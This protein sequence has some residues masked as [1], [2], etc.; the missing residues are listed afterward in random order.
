MQ[1]L[2]CATVMKSTTEDL[3]RERDRVTGADLVELRLDGL[4][5]PD[6]AAALAG[7][8]LPVIVTCRPS[9]EG[10]GFTGTEDDR[11]RILER[12]LDLGADY[13]DLEAGAPFTQDLIRRRGGRR[14]VLSQHSFD[15][16]PADLP[17]RYAAMQASGAEVVKIA[18][19]ASRL[20]D[21]LPLFALADGR[22]PDF[23]DHVLIGMGAAG[24]PSR[25][26]GARLHNRW[27]YA[28]EGVA[29]G[30]FPVA[31]LLSTFRFRRI[32]ADAA[33]YGVV[34][35]PVMHSLSP[36]MHNAGFAA[37]MLNAAYVPLQARDAADFVEF[38]RGIDLRG[39]SITAPFKVALLAHMDEIDALARRVGAINT[40][41]VRDGRWVGANTDVDGFLAPLAA[42]IS[43]K[44]VRTTVLG[45][46]GAA[47][48]VAVALASQ[49]AAV[50]VSARRPEAAGEIASLAGGRVA[51]FPP[52]GGTW[53]VLVNATS[54][55]GAS[56]PVNPIAGAPL[57]GE[58]VFDLVYA[59]AETQLLAAARA[60]GCL[61]IGGL[62]MLIAQAERQFEL[63]TGMRPPAG[64]F[65][66]VAVRAAADSSG[67][68]E[69]RGPGV[70]AAVRDGGSS[71]THPG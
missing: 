13:V 11:R 21:L 38:A 12:A 62:E 65:Q 17:A 26:L 9:W 15:R 60:A 46:G 70:A 22:R 34:G 4:A 5:Q 67:T 3:V 39:A 33:L 55:G 54:A 50:T 43:L 25:V 40:L 20:S 49:G 63:W 57:D 27:T 29:P 28:G 44:G 52:R 58:I 71:R 14:I 19:G 66:S 31:H 47:R 32:R 35:N 36:V 48:A 10:G 41:V 6:V 51:G 37:L 23:R 1:P 59:P 42:R 68:G 2:L 69:S 8:R 7:R 56:D 64:L 24:V 53:D 18:V 45:S 61:A 16:V 30:Q